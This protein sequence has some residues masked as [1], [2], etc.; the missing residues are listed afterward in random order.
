MNNEH[1]DNFRLQYISFPDATGDHMSGI[2][3]VLE[4]GGKWIQLRMKNC[5]L[6]EIESVARE[7]KILCKTYNATFILND[8][9]ELVKKLNL[10]GVHVGKK[11]ITAV[12]ARDI[13]GEDKILGRTCNTFEDLIEASKLPIDYIGFGPY[14]F[15]Q[16]KDNIDGVLGDFTFEKLNDWNETYSLKP[17]VGIGGIEVEDINTLT[18]FGI[19]GIAAS[20]MLRNKTTEEIK[21]IVEDINHGFTKNRR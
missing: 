7:V 19:K 2:K 10:D 4:G 13:I 1:L 14:K 20:G 12:K 21:N 17:I 5:T 3:S 18:T 6:Q 9:P 15:T 11:D 8:Y 16:T